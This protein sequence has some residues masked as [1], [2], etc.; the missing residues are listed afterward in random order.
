MGLREEELVVGTHGFPELH[1]SSVGDQNHRSSF[2]G[3][4]SLPRCWGRSNLHR[5]PYVGSSRLDQ[6]KS[7]L[8]SIP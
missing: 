3:N 6:V 1:S 7:D 5:P 4:G 8:P 2:L